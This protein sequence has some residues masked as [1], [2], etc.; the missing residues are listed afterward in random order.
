MLT[1]LVILTVGST[2]IFLDIGFTVTTFFQ[3]TPPASLHSVWA[4]VLTIIWPAVAAFIYFIVQ[5]VVVVRIL[6]E[7]KPLSASPIDIRIR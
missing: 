6:K 3:S 7:S 5:I 4:F 2:Y 1:G